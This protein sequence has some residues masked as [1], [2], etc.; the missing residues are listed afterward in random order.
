MI[1]WWTL[2]DTRRRSYQLHIHI[3]EALSIMINSLLFVLFIEI[4]VFM[5]LR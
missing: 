5:L 2:L 4:V 3:M 1:L